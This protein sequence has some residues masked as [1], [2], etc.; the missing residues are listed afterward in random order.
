MEIRICDWEIAQTKALHVYTSNLNASVSTNIAHISRPW[1]E[2]SE[3][4]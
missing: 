4:H 3:L 1:G 2:E